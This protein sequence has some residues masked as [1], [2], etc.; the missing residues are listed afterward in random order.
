MT[1]CSN[2]GKQIQD[3]SEFCSGCGQRL[4]NQVPPSSINSNST[5]INN[6]NR[7]PKA[8]RSSNMA[9]C[10]NCGK[11]IQDNSEFCSSCGQR[12]NNQAPPPYMNYN[13]AYVNN[14]P[15][16]NLVQNLSKKVK[17]NAIIWI[18]VASLQ[19][20]IGL[21][22]LMIGI[23]YNM[24]YIYLNPG[25]TNIVLG[26]FVLLVS[27]LNYFG[28]ARDFKY[29]KEVL[30][31]PVGIVDKFSPIGGCVANLIYNL[32]LGGVIGIAGSIYYFFVRSFVNS[33]VV[34][35]YYYCNL[36]CIQMS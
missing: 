10:Q 26:L 9:F 17:I 7:E 21:A 29:S 12:L 6:D 24:A 28:A 23:L 25:T 19:V 20:V 36:C 34:L 15:T 3:N 4:N 30:V 32:L 16:S 2:C 22:N 8:E 27:A 31:K 18:V 13:Y 14:N 1:Y 33:N 11:Q 5:C 35:R